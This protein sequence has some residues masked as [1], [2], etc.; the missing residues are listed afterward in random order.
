MVQVLGPFAEATKS[1]EGDSY[2]TLSMVHPVFGALKRE[3]LQRTPQDSPFLRFVKG[4]LENNLMLHWSEKIDGTVPLL[5]TF[6]D[7][8]LLTP[9]ENQDM[10]EM[11]VIEASEELARDDVGVVTTTNAVP[12]WESESPTVPRTQFQKLLHS[13]M[14]SAPSARRRKG[15]SGSAIAPNKE[16]VA[17]EARSDLAEIPCPEDMPQLEWWNM[18][19]KNFPKLW[20]LALPFLT[21]PARSSTS[22]RTL[23]EAGSIVEDQMTALTD[24]HVDHRV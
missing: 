7:P 10:Q 9:G 11:F 5:A 22:E 1:V 6:L 14:C 20:R 12:S 23:S 2:V 8:R 21:P 15:A 18:Y 16:V 13:A 3:V 24:E 4:A 19:D 17:L